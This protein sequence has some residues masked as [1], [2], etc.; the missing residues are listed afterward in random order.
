[1]RPS[2]SCLRLAFALS[3]LVLVAGLGCGDDSSN[4]GGS[5]G[6]AT[7]TA[8]GGGGVGGN[9]SGTGGG[10]L[11]GG[12]GET[13]GGEAGGQ[14]GG[15]DCPDISCTTACPGDPWIDLDGCPTCACAADLE[16]TVTNFD[17]P[18]QLVSASVQASHFIG[19]IDRWVFDFLWQYDD[20]NASDDAED[21]VTSV[22][23]MQVGPQFEPTEANVT[24]FTPEDDGNPLEIVNSQYTLH[25]FATLTADLIPVDGFFSIRRVG[26]NFEG[27]VSLDFTVS[28]G[29]S[30]QTVHVAT[31]F[32]APVP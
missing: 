16:M 3:A 11:G 26:G 32:S 7:G 1:M 14:G 12:G 4:S 25:G 13:G 21:V 24:Y 9:S 5:G 10:Q 31:P 20:P 22:R 23:I 15:P 29:G 27:H 18:V 28:G 6:S 2:H 17:K 19:G 8:S 30:P